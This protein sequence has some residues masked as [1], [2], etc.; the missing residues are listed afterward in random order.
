MR[1]S[2]P[3]ANELRK[4]TETDFPA[5]Y[6]SA[7]EES[8]GGQRAF[9]HCMRLRLVGLFVAAVGGAL[10]SAEGIEWLGGLI[11]VA[12]LLVALGAE[13]YTITVRPD[14]IW[15]EGRAAAESVKTLAWRYMV[16]GEG[17]EDEDTTVD[18]RFETQLRDLFTDLDHVPTADGEGGQISPLMRQVRAAA[19]HDRIGYYREFRVV[20]QLG[21]YSRK[22]KFN[23][24]RLRQWTAATVVFEVVG[25]FAA[26][27]L[28]ARVIDFDALGLVSA[29]ASSLTAWAQSRQYQTL[30]SAYSVTS[31]EVASV[32][33]QLDSLK[34]ES[35]WARF[36]GEAEEAFSREHTLWRASRGIRVG[37][38]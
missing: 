15:Y 33:S 4:P 12:A 21:W 11:A 14:R 32:L 35:A 36:V 26:A 24:R 37:G 31:Q 30:S 19:F 1:S 29:L 38:R 27:L 23:T 5:L 22:A 8:L 9:A 17:F 6:R 20:D 3:S 28:W 2:S 7:D 25:I 34:S 10:T 13:L 16:R 18:A